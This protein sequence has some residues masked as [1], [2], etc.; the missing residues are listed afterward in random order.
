LKAENN[1]LSAL[2]SEAWKEIDKLKESNKEMSI[3]IATIK[4]I[5]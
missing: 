1:E 5:L 4:S 2:L 3:K